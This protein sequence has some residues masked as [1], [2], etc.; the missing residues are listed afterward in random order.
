[1]IKISISFHCTALHV[2]VHDKLE[3]RSDYHIR[4]FCSGTALSVSLTTSVSQNS[5]T[6]KETRDRVDWPESAV[7]TKKERLN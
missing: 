1:M 2:G 4:Q 3:C 6:S 7:G 5:A